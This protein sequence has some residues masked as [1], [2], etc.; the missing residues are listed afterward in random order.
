MAEQQVTWSE[1]QAELVLKLHQK[2]SELSH[3]KDDLRRA[4]IELERE[5]EKYFTPPSGPDRGTDKDK[6]GGI[7]VTLHLKNLHHQRRFLCGVCIVTYW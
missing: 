5:R 3:L 6:V 1:G 7:R 4:E 2:E